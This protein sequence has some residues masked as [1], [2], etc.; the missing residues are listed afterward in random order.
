MLNSNAVIPGGARNLAF[1]VAII[2][3]TLRHAATN[4]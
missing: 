1:E 4:G 3:A 2:L